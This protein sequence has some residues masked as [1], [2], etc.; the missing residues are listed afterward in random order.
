MFLVFPLSNSNGVDTIGKSV[1]I[2]VIINHASRLQLAWGY[3][4]RCLWFVSGEVACHPFGAILFC[5][6]A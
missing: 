6:Q 4:E 1:E 5:R 3:S 2:I